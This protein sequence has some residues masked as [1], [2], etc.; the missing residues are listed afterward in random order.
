MTFTNRLVV[1]GKNAH[2]F[3][4][5]RF[6]TR[7]FRTIK[8]Q[9]ILLLTVAGRTSGTP[10]TTPVVYLRDGAS[11]V[12]AGSNGGMKPEPQWFR[13][14]RAASAANI[15]VDALRTE[16]TVRV[17]EGAEYER[18]WAARVR[19]APF[20]EGYAS[21]SGRVIPLAVLTPTA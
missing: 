10:I 18:L 19:T 3:L 2:T 14:L 11:Y 8:G 4:Y 1:F 21:K 6:D 12:V 20:F 13:N 5:R 16:V 15:E 17:A 7:I 9:P